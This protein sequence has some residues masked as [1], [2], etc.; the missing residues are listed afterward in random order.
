MKKNSVINATWNI[1]NADFVINLNY[2]QIEVLVFVAGSIYLS[3]GT[4][5]AKTIRFSSGAIR[6]ATRLGHDLAGADKTTRNAGNK[7]C[8]LQGK[9]DHQL[10][11]K[12]PDF[13]PSLAQR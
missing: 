7:Q 1:T 6:R 8:L 5:F 3:L 10:A 4:L 11:K 13:N 2:L 12:T 9:H